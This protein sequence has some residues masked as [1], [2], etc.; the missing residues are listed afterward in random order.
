MNESFMG[1]KELEAASLD[2]MLISATPSSAPIARL[3]TLHCGSALDGFESSLNAALVGSNEYNSPVKA[4]VA[5]LRAE[6][7]H[8]GTEVEYSL[9]AV[10]VDHPRAP[11]HRGIH[12]LNARYLVAGPSKVRACANLHE[13]EKIHS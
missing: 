7:P 4:H 10:V 6:L 5:N 11:Q 13:L 1:I 2:A 8:V 12:R 3:K 9:N